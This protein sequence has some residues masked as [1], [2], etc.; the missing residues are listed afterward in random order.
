MKKIYAV[1]F[2]LFSVIAFGQIKGTVTDIKGEPLAFVSIYIENTYIGTTTNE[3]GK[4]ELN[5]TEDKKVNVVYQYLG[6][7]TQ[8]N[9]LTIDK[10]PFTNDVKLIEENFNLTEIVLTEGENP[11]NAVEETP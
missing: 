9:L 5:Y 6:Y 2:G 3:N 7:K 11:A 8:K 10:Y 4:Y 1:V